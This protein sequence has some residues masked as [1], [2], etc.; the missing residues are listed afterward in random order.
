[1]RL[2]IVLERTEVEKMDKFQKR[3]LLIMVSLII[4]FSLVQ[5]SYGVFFFQT[6]EQSAMALL[7]GLFLFGVSG[8]FVTD[9]LEIS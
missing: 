3:V 2:L 7:S 8:M 4:I 1:M 9:L 6:F 5:I